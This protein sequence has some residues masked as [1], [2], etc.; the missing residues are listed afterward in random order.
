[1][2]DAAVVDASVAV[3]WVVDEPG[4]RQARGLSRARL[5]APDLLPVE[6]ANILWRKARVG[7][8][9]ADEA[10][11]RLRLLRQAPVTLAGSGSLLDTALDLSRDL[12]HPVY[13][14]V[15]LALALRREIPLVTA[16]KRF[17][18]A[19]RKSGRL[20]AHIVALADLPA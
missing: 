4:S 5:E 3:K 11:V 13:D 12:G 2:I 10:A 6:C 19:L 16:D 18:A 14:C 1:M 7:D 15:Y 8:L 20:A 9:T 17:V